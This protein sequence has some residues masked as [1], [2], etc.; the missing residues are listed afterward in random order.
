MI[1]WSW[2]ILCKVMLETSGRCFL[3]R[4]DIWNAMLC[5][6]MYQ[7]AHIQLQSI[8]QHT[9][10]VNLAFAT[11]PETV[12]IKFIHFDHNYNVSLHPS[13]H[14]NLFYSQNDYALHHNYISECL[15]SIC[16]TDKPQPPPNHQDHTCTKKTK[17]T[18][19]PDSLTFIY[20]QSRTSPRKC[21]H[22][23]SSR[24]T[25]KS[26]SCHPSIHPS[27]HPSNYRYINKKREKQL[28]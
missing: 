9:P 18:F 11:T 28:K 19:K 24:N 21:S 8:L 26:P 10:M 4:C 12:F 22:H 17:K 23:L 3:C 15:A 6:T 5:P 16:Q 20:I 14:L 1:S 27:I 2:M 13:C 25:P 7:Q